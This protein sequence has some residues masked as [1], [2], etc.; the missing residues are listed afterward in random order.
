[1]FVF[2]CALTVILQLVGTQAQAQITT[3]V[4]RRTMLVRVPSG[5]VVGT[6]FTIEVDSRQYLVTAKHILKE[7]CDREEG[8]IEV[9]KN[10]QWIPLKVEILKCADPV[11]IAVIV[12]PRQ[13]TITYTLPPSCEGLILGQDTYFVGYPLGI[14]EGTAGI[15]SNLGLVK[16]A[17]LSQF[18][19]H[20]ECGSMRFLL[21][22]CNNP[23]YSGSPLVFSDTG[24]VL[25]VAGVMSGYLPQLTEVKRVHEIGSVDELREAVRTGKE[26]LHKEG[27][28][29]VVEETN[30]LFASINSGIATAWDIKSA[31][32]LIRKNPVGP[33]A[34]ENFSE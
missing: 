4:L 24:G 34:E 19:V 6:A 14:A 30:D 16:K 5:M 2:V 21:D 3:N 9:F 28:E 23:G 22:G 11:D 17:V 33:L 18:D 25:K 15:P 29:F 26:I 20:P 13:L 32:E 8:L 27:N 1:M 31:V 10:R 12:P 7:L